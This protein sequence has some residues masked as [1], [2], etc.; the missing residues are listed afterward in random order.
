[1]QLFD[2]VEQSFEQNGT[3]GVIAELYQ[4]EKR[5]YVKCLKCNYESPQEAKFFD[6]Q[7][8]VQN[9]FENVQNSSIEQAL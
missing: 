5:D 9:Q 8:V 4:G 1:M 6:L 7:L 3:Y 2:A